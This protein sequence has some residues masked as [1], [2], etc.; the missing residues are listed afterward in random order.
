MRS[1]VPTLPRYFLS[2]SSVHLRPAGGAWQQQEPKSDDAAGSRWVEKLE[3]PGNALPC[4][5]KL[6]TALVKTAVC[7]V[8]PIALATARSLGAPSYARKHSPHHHELELATP[9]GAPNITP[10]PAT[11]THWTRFKAC[12]FAS[13]PCPCSTAAASMATWRIHTI[14]AAHAQSQ[15]GRVAGWGNN[16]IR[17]RATARG[18]LA[19]R[20]HSDSIQ[21]GLGFR[22]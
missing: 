4:C 16:S 13:R 9:Q 21:R 14:H 11:T 15:H 8:C 17:N 3:I 7:T 18:P 22:V 10:R 6:P 2:T 1:C 12:S 19:P 5:C 20:Q